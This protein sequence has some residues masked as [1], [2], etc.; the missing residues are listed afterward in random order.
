MAVMMTGFSI[1]MISI[2][3]Q[4]VRH[5]GIRNIDD[6]TAQRLVQFEVNLNDAEWPELAQL[7]TIGPIMAKRI[8][9]YRRANGPFHSIEDVMQV[10]GIGSKTLAQ[11]SPYL[12][13]DNGTEL[14]ETVASGPTPGFRGSDPTTDNRP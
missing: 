14:L 10:K 7:P 11:I 5:D 2:I 8:V 9:H 4:S 3:Y 1:M 6:P 13:V 12:S